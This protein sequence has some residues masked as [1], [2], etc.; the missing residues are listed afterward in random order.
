MDFLKKLQERNILTYLLLIFSIVTGFFLFAQVLIDDAF[1]FFSYGYNL[2]HHGFFN[3]HADNNY[4]E[5]Y[6]SYIVALLSIVPPLLNIEPFIFIKMVGVFIFFLIIY[7][8]FKTVTNKKTAL[9]TIVIFVTN[10]NTYVH[11][12]A[13]LETL[14]WLW[15]LLELFI[16]LKNIEWNTFQQLKLCTICLLLPLTRPEGAI[17]VFFAF[18]YLILSKKVKFNNFILVVFFVVGL[19]YYVWRTI[20]YGFLFPMPF[21]QKA[22]NTPIRKPF[23]LFIN[24]Y[25]SWQYLLC[26]FLLYRILK[27]DYL[28]NKL[29]LVCFA[30][31][32][33]LY[34]F[35]FLQMNYAER[36]PFQL[37][38]PLILFSIMEMESFSKQVQSKI[39]YISTFF[40]LILLTKGLNS[41]SISESMSSNISSSFYLPRVHYTFAKHLNRMHQKNVTVLF[42]DAG[43]LPY[44][45]HVKCVDLHGLADNFLSKNKMT[46]AYFDTIHADI[47]LI[48]SFYKEQK[49]LA[50][51]IGNSKIV[52]DFIDKDS[53]Y[54]YKGVAITSERFYFVHCYVNQKSPYKNLTN[55]AIEN[56]I[57]EA[58]SKELD[59]KKLVK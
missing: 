48:G 35:S 13:G 12:F 53:S 25:T 43:M 23:L 21:Y 33:G 51:E 54:S 19:S 55:I 28:L 42:G 3:W 30:L 17:F 14:I 38:F 15:L 22:I 31:F 1:I 27:T 7:R 56:A 10:W 40:I 26:V 47:I 39:K 20:Q 2:I 36:F 50:E 41:E 59:I 46:R 32:F 52:Y 6:T 57:L 9:F 24:V 44:Y 37:F 8:I 4:V 11:T 45:A 18:F 58:N 49:K 5:A 16:Q 29:Y 34:G